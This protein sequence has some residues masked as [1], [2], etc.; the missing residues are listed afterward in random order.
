MSF[1]LLQ[2]IQ[3]PKGIPFIELIFAMQRD[4]TP[5]WFAMRATYRRELDAAR[6]LKD[7]GID[8]FIPMTYVYR[9]RKGKRVRQ[10][11]PVVR[12]LIFVYACQSHLQQVK[13]EILFLQYIIDSRTHQKIIVPDEQMRRFIA[14]T[15]TYDDQLLYFYPEEL[16]LS[17]GTRVRIIGGEFEG[18]EGV[19]IKVKGVRD[20]RVVIAVEGVIAVAM[21]TIHPD[22][23]EVIEA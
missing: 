23:I 12:N 10:L 2:G 3:S 17:K 14:V 9:I 22:L 16:N 21:T 13:N 20:R 4:E 7:A 6:L 18:Y 19:F 11:V 5:R 8:T 15:G 1:C